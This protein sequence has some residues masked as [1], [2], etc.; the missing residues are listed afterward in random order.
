MGKKRTSITNRNKSDQHD[1]PGRIYGFKPK[2]NRP[3]AFIVLAFFMI[4]AVVI[5]G[6]AFYKSFEE[7]AR[8]KQAGLGPVAAIYLA[9]GIG[10]LALVAFGM[11]RTFVWYPSITVTE[12][13]LANDT[14]NLRTPQLELNNRSLNIVLQCRIQTRRGHTI[15]WWLLIDKHG[16]LYLDQNTGEARKLAEILSS[17]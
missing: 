15:G 10:V 2:E 14:L 6:G 12:F 13:F 1:A 3:L 5:A 9:V 16:W 4:P 8:Q 7:Y 11:W 17:R